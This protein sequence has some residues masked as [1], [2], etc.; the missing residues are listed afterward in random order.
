M[1]KWFLSK[2]SLL[3]VFCLQ[4]S[5]YCG[6]VA[7]TLVKTPCGYIPI[8]KLKTKDVVYGID[9]NG[10]ISPTILTHTISYQRKK[11]VHIVIEN[12]RLIVAQS[13]KFLLPL[14][15]V[16]CKAKKIHEKD[17]ILSAFHDSIQ[18][19][20]VQNKDDAITFY[21]IR[22]KKDHAFL[23]TKE[24]IIV[25]NMPLF[26]IGA[27][28][29]FE[30]L[31]FTV[32]MVWTGVCLFGLWFG[33]T[34]LPPKKQLMPVIQSK[35]TTM[36][37]WQPDQK[38]N[39]IET[40]SPLPVDNRPKHPALESS[41]LPEESKHQTPIGSTVNQPIEEKPCNQTLDQP[42]Q[43]ECNF[44]LSQ[45]AYNQTYLFEY[46]SENTT[47]PLTI[48]HRE[49]NGRCNYPPSQHQPGKSCDSDTCKP[50]RIGPN[51]THIPSPKHPSNAAN[52]NVSPGL[53]MEEGQK[54]LDESVPIIDKEGNVKKSRVAVWDGKFV[55]FEK[56]SEKV[57]H[58]HIRPWTANKN[59]GLQGLTQEM[60]NALQTA[61]LVNDK[62]KIKNKNNI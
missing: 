35:A 11:Y 34:F 8:E 24:D 50:P 38:N 44:S 54:A 28:I 3:F 6:F 61:G 45:G 60:K 21:D 22:L 42:I 15:Y 59:K 13:Q 57:Y 49:T 1:N 5:L 36:D 14:K 12:Q 17:A 23:V 47:K 56:T 31:K 53:D 46:S 19:K 26:S 39:F 7:G 41:Y 33:S 51:G 9:K 10:N 2:I 25:H 37:L 58:S 4:N 29:S 62:G 27:L 43:K 55:I 18:V 20:I 32:E 16:W 40:S 30:G 48:L 52:D